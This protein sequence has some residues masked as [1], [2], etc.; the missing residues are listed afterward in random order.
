[1]HQDF[2]NNSGNIDISGKLENSRQI[3]NSERG[4]EPMKFDTYTQGLLDGS[5]DMTA[6][7]YPESKD[8]SLKNMAD[9]SDEEQPDHINSSPKISI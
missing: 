8:P 9:N 4:L 7:N 1:M 2:K 6:F 5:Y 3:E